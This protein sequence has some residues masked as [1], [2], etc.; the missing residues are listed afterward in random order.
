[1]ALA[2]PPHLQ[3]FTALPAAPAVALTYSGCFPSA[4]AWRTACCKVAPRI[5]PAL[6]VATDT[7]L[8][9]PNPSHEA[10]FKTE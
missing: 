2:V 7:T 8:S 6:S 1:M 9:M 3:P 4:R 10:A 5:L